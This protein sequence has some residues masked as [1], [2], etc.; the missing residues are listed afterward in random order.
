VALHR[1]ALQR[2]ADTAPDRLPRNKGRARAKASDRPLWFMAPSGIVTTMVVLVPL[3]LAI[4]ISLIDLDQYTLRRW[5]TAPFIGVQNYIEAITE[6]PLLRSILISVALALL[7]TLLSIPIGVTAALV[8]HNRYRGLAVI[9]SMF[10]IP[11][12]LPLFVVGSIWRAILQPDGALNSALAALGIRSP[13]WLNG[14][15]SFW[16]L[17]A[18][19]TWN[20][21]PFFYMLALASLQTVPLEVHEAA[22]LDGASWSK[23]LWYV[24]LPHVRSSIALASLLGALNTINNFSL[25]YVLFGSPAPTDVN[26]LPI[27]TYATSFQS[28]RFGLSAAMAVGSLLLVLVP[29]LIYARAVRLD[30]G[31]GSSR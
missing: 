17:V 6:T 25:A 5:I 3:G 13:L 29:L 16:S 11:Y 1:T 31:E 19:Q 28:F 21:W 23:K 8:T 14:P 20:A 24:V 30:Q 27:L 18:A 9:R 22:T 15:G 10:L 7:V 4:F 12:V 26:V 2:P